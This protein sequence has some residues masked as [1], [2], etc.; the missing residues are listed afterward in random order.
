M[1]DFIPLEIVER[2]SKQGLTEME[3]I[4]Q[5]KLR[6]FHEDQI[7]RAVNESIKQGVIGKPGIPARP[8]VDAGENNIDISRHP[9]PALQQPQS[10]LP[11][12]QPVSMS[13]PP[14]EISLPDNIKPMELSEIG[15]GKAPKPLAGTAA[16]PRPLP[17]QAPAMPKPLTTQPAAPK[18]LTGIPTQ[19]RPIVQPTP[20][21][22]TPQPTR[23][24]MPIPMQRPVQ[25]PAPIPQP[26]PLPKPVGVSSFK[27][28]DITI[29]EL[30][31]EVVNT[32]I[33]KSNKKISELL[34]KDT[35]LHDEIQT[36]GKKISKLAKVTEKKTSETESKV[37]DISSRVISMENRISALEQA[38]KSFGTAVSRTKPKKK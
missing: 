26:A 3:I 24:P 4:S 37:G 38:F 5:L 25:Q 7:N 6:G 28:H 20:L 34:G 14:E 22:H 27:Q 13:R 12:K 16:Q 8:N 33:K 35:Q 10:S 19:P 9:E 23:A 17:T 30:V 36:I 15:F 11:P 29:E 21:A 31:E 2:L 1:T 32:E 18:P